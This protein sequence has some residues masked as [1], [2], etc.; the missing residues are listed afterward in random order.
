MSA[1]FFPGLALATGLL[2]VAQGLVSCSGGSGGGSGGIGDTT[3]MSIQCTSLGCV[4]STSNPGAQINCGVTEVYVNQEIRV[5]FTNPVDLVTVNNNSFQ[6]VE[7]GT[8]KTPPGSFTLDPTDPRVLVY[9][10]QLTFDSSG[11]PIYGLER[12][13]T[14][15]LKIPG[16]RLDSLGPY[17]R[18]RVGSANTNRLQCTLVASRG[19]F[20]ASPGSPGVTVTLDTVKTRDPDGNPIE[21]NVNVPARGAVDVYRN[22]PIRMVFNDVMDPANLANP[23][24]GTSD[25]IKLAVDADGDTTNDDDQV[26]ISGTFTLT[27]DQNALRT[28]VVFQPSGGIPSAGH[29]PNPRRIVLEF[30]SDITDLGGNRLINPGL[31]VFTPEL[32]DFDPL[33]LTEEFDSSLR[34]DTV[35]TGGTWRFGSLVAGKGGG[36]GRLG[37]LIVPIGTVVELSTD[38]EDFSH[39]ADQPTIFNPTNVLDRPADLRVTD[40]VFEFSRLRIDAGAVLRFRG[41][42]PARIYVRGEAVVQGVID[43]SG[44]SGL[45]HASN[46]LPGGVGGTP[47]P[48]GGRGGDGGARPDGTA[49]SSVCTLCANPGA[50]PE[51]VLDPSTYVFV[52]GTDGEGI[53]FPNTIDPL[54]TRVA[55][56][57]GGIAWPQPSPAN[58]ALHMPSILT[59]VSGLEVD[60]WIECRATAPGSPGSGGAH[61]LDGGVGI[62]KTGGLNPVTQPPDTAPGESSELMIDDTVKSLAPEL[63]LLRGG[64][65]GG[66]GGGHLQRTQVNG[67]ILVDCNVAVPQGSALQVADYVSHS[68]AGGG[69]GAGGLQITAGRRLI[70]N[71][72]IDA[73]GGDGGSGTFPPL[74]T[75]PND[76]A[77]AG[78]GGAG[79]AVLLQSPLIQVQAVPGRIKVAGGE[80]GSGTGLAFPLTASTGGHGSPGFLRMEANTAPVIAQEAF[81]ILPTQAELQE[82]YGPTVTIRDIFTTAVW[83]PVVDQP[84]GMSGAQSCWIRPNGS[85]FTL[86]FEADGAEPGWDMELEI[87]GQTELQSYRGP[88]DLFP[89]SLE[90]T[91][92][93]EI[94]SSPL[95]VRFQGARAVGQLV[96]PCAVIDVGAGSQ[97]A[98]GSLSDWVRHPAELNDFFAEPSLSPNIFRFVVLWDRSR[99]E[100]QQLVDI[101]SIH[102]VIQPD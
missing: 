66:G 42:N 79:G 54:A 102:F 73:S 81:K 4:A 58:P 35:R 43:V 53:E 45:L 2:G 41:A 55:F 28:T 90:D 63:G 26:P 64:A 68:S 86:L 29:G 31:I 12:D 51:D 56:G 57:Q 76:L 77:Q 92:G 39:L 16:T 46:E 5:T 85:F 9:R 25:S 65:G 59:D 98:E 1:R 96:D 89:T 3:N 74:P 84:T 36:S 88:N 37:D 17:I 18:N 60:K 27:I 94:G 15:F 7:F 100:F 38:D 21:L 83:T 61:S 93:S 6:M 34:E 24:S 52:N 50:G 14:Y 87:E 22:S 40:G 32:I 33:V 62:L 99:P 48:N 97:L 30:T 49:F 8:G 80:G 91:W 23:V 71:G 75:N 101:E 20:D 70:V 19:V 69:G 47:G 44:A 95:V 78:G 11:N 10:P 72:V 13:K 82:V 67:F